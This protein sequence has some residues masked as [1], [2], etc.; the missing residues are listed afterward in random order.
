MKSLV[1]ILMFILISNF[2]AQVGRSFSLLE[3]KR[4]CLENHAKITNASLEYDKAVH[5]KREY[6]AAGMPEANITGAFNQFLN[7]PVQVL[8]ISFLTQQLLRMK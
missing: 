8:P 2:N 7:L 5:K 1:T 6:L 3:A 4:I